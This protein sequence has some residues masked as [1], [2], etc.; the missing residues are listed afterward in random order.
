M[1]HPLARVAATCVGGTVALAPVVVAGPLTAAHPSSAGGVAALVGLV[2][3]TSLLPMTIWAIAAPVAGSVRSAIGGAIELPALAVTGLVLGEALQVSHAASGALVVAAIVIAP[4]RASDAPPDGRAWCAAGSGAA[5]RW[6][7]SATR[8]GTP[9]RHGPRSTRH[10]PGPARRGQRPAR[11]GQRPARRASGPPDAASGPPDAASGPPDAASGPPDAAASGPPDAAAS[12]RARRC[13]RR[14]TA[15]TPSSVHSMGTDLLVER[16]GFD[17]D[18]LAANRA[19]HLS[20]RQAAR[21]ER[22]SRIE[23]LWIG[24]G[25]VAVFVGAVLA[26]ALPEKYVGAAAMIVGIVVVITAVWC[27]GVFGGPRQTA[28]CRCSR[29]GL[30]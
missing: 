23:T 6:A 12:G 2:V 1:L 28:R 14:S 27:C 13:G 30:V 7:G 9:A 25:V 15:I 3:C 29:G 16:F 8:C 19:G 17:D 26:I 18:D 24:L 20:Q 5:R 21:I 22:T 11:R 10:G 4:S